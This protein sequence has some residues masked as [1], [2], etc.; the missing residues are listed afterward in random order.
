MLCQAVVMFDR[1]AFE[2]VDYLA[3]KGQLGFQGTW[4]LPVHV[5]RDGQFMA[6]AE[7]LQLSGESE[8]M[9]GLE[10]EKRC[11]DTIESVTLAGQMSCIE[12]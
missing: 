10:K 6:L 9:V 3:W 12:T 1:S 5:L 4:I 2:C 8:Q 7:C 11:S